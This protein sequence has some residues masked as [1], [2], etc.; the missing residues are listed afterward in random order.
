[1]VRNISTLAFRAVQTHQSLTS[2]V[3]RLQRGFLPLESVLTAQKELDELA[4]I[5]DSIRA[6]LKH[7]PVYKQTEN[8]S[9]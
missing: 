3:T 7:K 4:K 9:Q 6:E 8:K 5:L 2:A 1:M